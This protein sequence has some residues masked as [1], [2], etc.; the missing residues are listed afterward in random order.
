MAEER[1]VM[2]EPRVWPRGEPMLLVGELMVTEAARVMRVLGC[3]EM[4]LV[5][6]SVAVRAVVRLDIL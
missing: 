2:L 6:E 1:F 4:P 5:L 3:R